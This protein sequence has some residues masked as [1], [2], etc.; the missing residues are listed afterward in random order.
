LFL[1][2]VDERGAFPTNA[3]RLNSITPTS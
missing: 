3:I 2:N 1:Y